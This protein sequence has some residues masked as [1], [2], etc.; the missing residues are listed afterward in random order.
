[1]SY[2]RWSDDSDVYV[3]DDICGAIACREC[4]LLGRS[5]YFESRADAVA[6]LRA[7]ED[8]GHKVPDGVIEEIESDAARFGDDADCWE[9]K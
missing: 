6:H 3:Y 2:C 7:H 4:I 9:G 1:M 8:A 5:Q